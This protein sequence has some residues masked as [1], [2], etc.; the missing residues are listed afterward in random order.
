MPPLLPAL[1]LLLSTSLASA[2]APYA[3]WTHSGSV[4][5]LTTPEGANLP[6]AA[7]AENFPLLVRLQADTFNFSQAQP[8]GQDLRFASDDGTP[9]PYQIE[10]WDP[11]HGRASVWVRVPRIQGNASQPLHLF[12]GHPSAPSESSGPAVFNAA[13]GYCRVWHLGEDL[14]DDVTHHPLKNQ[15]TTLVPGHIGAARHLAGQQGL[16]GGQDIPDFPTDSA[17]HTTQAWF[18]AEKSNGTILAWGNEQSQGKVVMQFRSPSHVNMDC[19]FS[20]ANI[21][22]SSPVPLGEWVHVVHC[23]EKGNTKLYLNGVLDGTNTGRGAPL[24]LHRPAKLWLG[25]WYANYDFVGDI[26]EV[27]LSNVS[28]SPHWV[29]LEYENQKALQTLVGPVVPPGDSFA[30]APS[31]ATL[32]EAEPTTFTAS[33]GG[34]QKLTWILQRGDRESV[35]AVDQLSFTLQPGRVVGNQALT[36]KLR[37]LYPSGVKTTAAALVVQDTISEPDFT[38]AAPATWDGRT[39][40]EIAPV[41]R[42]PAPSNTPKLPLHWNW[43]LSGPAVDHLPAPEKLTLRRALGSGPLTITL[44]LDNGGAPTVHSTTIQIAPPTPEP[45]ITRQPDAAAQPQDNQFYAREADGFGT[46]FCRGTLTTPAPSTFLRLFADN[47]L[48]TEESQPTGPNNTYAYALK[49]KPG[50]IN[51]RIEFGTAKQVLHA[52][53]NLVCG[54]AFLIIGQS[55]AVSTDWGQDPAPPL[56]PW[57][58]TFGSTSGGPE[59]SRLATWAPA[60]AR[61]P[62]GKA[63]I[64]YWGM[65]LG[66][67]LVESQSRPICLINGA[68]GGT[69]IDQH[70]RSTSDPTDPTTIYGRLLWRVRQA[71]LTHGIRSILW[72]Q[73][74]NDQGADG[75]TGGFGYETYRAYFHQLAASW[76]QD[77]P[78]VQHFHL[79]QIWPKSCS[80]GFDGSDNRLREVQRTLP[81]DFSNLSILSTLGI[82]PPGGCHYPAAGYAEFARLLT[83][84]MERHHYGKTFPTSITPPNL[85]KAAFTSPARDAI[86]LTFDQPVAW[87]PQLAT[88]FYLDGKENLVAHGT[89]AGN[90][91]TLH[92]AEPSAAAHLTYLDSKAWSQDTLLLGTNGLAALTFCEVPLAAP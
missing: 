63:E 46:L 79:F 86:A 83:P 69:R 68:V 33:A 55:N 74:E 89:T 11:A 67:R 14:S 36:L 4:F 32:R 80:M 81:Q 38:L 5:I 65:E 9:L 21:K 56:N 23:Y 53:Q 73:G 52:A 66:R 62:G 91:L 28:R 7:S 1:A 78:N 6:A 41:V 75:P 17:P 77:Y 70:Q 48:L 50:L 64:G 92:L 27:R 59:E 15:A 82:N 12:W 30:L 60:T 3:D 76:K 22:G 8:Q 13:N 16:D 29:R 44:S 51:Y 84:L 58:R 87:S 19:Y 45:W 72:H 42:P 37:A 71:G 39:P 40:L 20:D 10:N 88:Q 18:R 2:A 26:D 57:V 25:G 47:Q 43:K 31:Q 24:K 90:T 54:D 49:L 85:L 61:A 35:V 34:A